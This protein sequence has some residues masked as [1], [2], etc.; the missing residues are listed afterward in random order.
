MM[1][2]DILYEYET[3]LIGK[4]NAMSNY[5]FTG[6]EERNEKRALYVFKYAIEFYLGWSPKQAISHLD[7]KIIRLMK[8]DQLLKY[9]IFPPEMNE[10]DD[11]YII[12][13][14]LYPNLV[15]LDEKEITLKVYKRVLEKDLYKF[16]KEYLSGDEQG[17]YRAIICFQYML[18][19]FTSFNNAQE[20][21]KF[22]ST[23][24]GTK[25]LKKYRLSIACISM[26]EHPIDFLHAS[27]PS[28]ARDDFWYRYYKFKLSNNEQIRELKKKNKFII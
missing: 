7:W 27:L 21:Y 18:S 13:G 3:V 12:L 1:Q 28:D 23:S 20:M 5:F 14:K 9:I 10:K 11:I 22:F 2:N 17:R 24:N 6:N 25:I 15:K 16:P 19:Q 8:L 4:K 26:F